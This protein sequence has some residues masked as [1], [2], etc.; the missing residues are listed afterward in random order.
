M[1]N[2]L[3]RSIATALVLCVLALGNAG[4][5]EEDD[6]NGTEFS[7]HINLLPD[8]ADSGGATIHFRTDL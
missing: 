3:L 2:H 1:R 4:C 7:V 5:Y 8:D 6:D